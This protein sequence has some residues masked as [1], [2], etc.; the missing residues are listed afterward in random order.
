MGRPSVAF[1]AAM[2]Y[3]LKTLRDENAPAKM[4]EVAAKEIAKLEAARL[5]NGRK[6]K[7]TLAPIEDA[8]IPTKDDAVA[9]MLQAAKP[10]GA[11]ADK[12]S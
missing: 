5:R 4:K 3:F 11:N 8:P 9:R 2:D 6:R 7:R 1:T 10:G 12:L